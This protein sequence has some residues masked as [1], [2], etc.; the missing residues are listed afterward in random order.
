M[1]STSIDTATD[2]QVRSCA[3]ILGILS[4]FLGIAGF[5]PG[6]VSLPAGYDAYLG[7]GYLFGIFPT[8][9]FHNAIGILVG[10]WGI[11][12]FTSLSGSIVFNRIFAL[13]YGAQAILGLLPF[14]NTFFG[15]MPLFGNNVWLS[16]ILAGVAFYFGYVK[17]DA[18]ILQQGVGT[19]LS[20]SL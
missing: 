4:L 13:I 3:L 17:S 8:N 19:P 10:L 6:V 11:A 12:A 2:G 15:T 18:T 20:N 7:N 16:V 1:R 14:T 5:V 9:Y